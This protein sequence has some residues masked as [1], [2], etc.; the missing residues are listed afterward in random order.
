MAVECLR[1]F[2]LVENFYQLGS[3]WLSEMFGLHCL[4]MC[5]SNTEA[6]VGSIL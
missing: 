4:I 6:S 3:L 5:N 2:R 1:H